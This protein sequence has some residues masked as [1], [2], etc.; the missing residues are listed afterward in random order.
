MCEMIISTVIHNV[1]KDATSHV[2]W[3]KDTQTHYALTLLYSLT[4]FGNTP[5]NM[6]QKT[7]LR[8]G[9]NMPS[10]NCTGVTFLVQNQ[11]QTC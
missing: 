1:N 11:Q 8:T 7:S 5:A 3:N 10:V 4:Y 2:D 6:F 9:S